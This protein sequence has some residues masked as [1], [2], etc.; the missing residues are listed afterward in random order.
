MLSES[1]R[2]AG[3]KFRARNDSQSNECLEYIEGTGYETSKVDMGMVTIC[4]VSGARS[5]FEV[6]A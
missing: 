5:G 3:G 1:R 4:P 2:A 6:D